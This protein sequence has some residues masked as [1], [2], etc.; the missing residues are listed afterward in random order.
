MITKLNNLLILE[1]RDGEKEMGCRIVN[2][3][4]NSENS[5]TQWSKSK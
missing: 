4:S 3:D 5:D 1:E 2:F